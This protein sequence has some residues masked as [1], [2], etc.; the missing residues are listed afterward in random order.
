[1]PAYKDETRG[2]WYV[3][4]YY[5]D[6][7]GKRRQKLKRGFKLQREAKEWEKT[8][9][10]QQSGTPEMTFGALCELYLEDCRHRNKLSTFKTK[11]S[12]CNTHL[13][14]YW[15]D[16][17]INQINAANVRKWQSTIISTGITP[18]YQYGV[19]K[20]FSMVMNFAVRYYGLNSNPCHLAGSIGK[21]NVH[22]LDFWTL[23]QFQK[24]LCTVDDL[25]VKTAFLVLFYTGMRCGE[26]LA[27]TLEDFAPDKGT[28]TINKTYHRYNKTDYITTPKTHNGNRTV[29]IPPFLVNFLQDY[30]SHVY[31]IKNNDRL[32][33]TLTPRKLQYAIRNGSE[34]ISMKPIPIHG[35]RHSHVS[36]LINMG[37]TPFLIA[38][39]I[40]DT[41]DM[42]NNVYGHL[43]PNRHKEVADKLQN[44]VSI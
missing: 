42:V 5:T 13:L 34:S 6:W 37:F 18:A 33:S 28:L 9:L 25:P 41:P 23:E 16:T 39:R 10:S 38:E 12:M 2:T 11:E 32:F 1:M 36:L 26:L 30:I 43:Y 21:S 35:L 20:L 44:L 14:P 17:P 27:L 4:L 15:K 31:G 3:K 19:H 22:R 8:F 7:T 40:G 29:T 24:F